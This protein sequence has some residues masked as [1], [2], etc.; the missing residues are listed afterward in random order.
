MNACNR[1]FPVMRGHGENQSVGG[2]FTLGANAEAESSARTTKPGLGHSSVGGDLATL[3]VSLSVKWGPT[4]I[5]PSIL[6]SFSGHGPGT[7]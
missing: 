2:F 5:L 1:L 3:S 4:T 7:C 6:S